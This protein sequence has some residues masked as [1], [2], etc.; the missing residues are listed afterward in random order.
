MEFAWVWLGQFRVAIEKN[1]L[2]LL[3]LW[4][5]FPVFLISFDMDCCLFNA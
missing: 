1:G 5:F 2:I 3:F 4:I